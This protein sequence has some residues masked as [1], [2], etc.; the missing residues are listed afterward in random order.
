MCL[1]FQPIRLQIFSA[2][3]DKVKYSTFWTWSSKKLN[4]S[5]ETPHFLWKGYIQFAQLKYLFS[6]THFFTVYSCLYFHFKRWFLFPKSMFFKTT[7]MLNR[8]SKAKLF[9]I[10]NKT[11]AQARFIYFPGWFINSFDT[12]GLNLGPTSPTT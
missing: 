4:G 7:L 11:P 2:V 8:Q 5:L 6:E 12:V 10:K 3:C 9:L 1:V